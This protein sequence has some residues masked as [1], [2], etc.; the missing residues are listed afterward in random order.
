MKLH[1]V[2]GKANTDADKVSVARAAGANY[3]TAVQVGALMDLLNTEMP[4]VDLASMLWSHLVDPQNG[5]VIFGK[6][7][8]ALVATW[9]RGGTKSCGSG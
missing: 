2:V 1:L 5:F 3:F 9:R 7:E 8:R 6:L 4:K